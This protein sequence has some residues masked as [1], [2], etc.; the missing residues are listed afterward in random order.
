M[1]GADL[2]LG[3][4]R[5]LYQESVKTTPAPDEFDMYNLTSAPLELDNMAGN[6]RWSSQEAHLRQPLVEQ[7]NRKRLTPQSGVIPGETDQSKR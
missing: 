3:D 1:Q 4:A 6:T 5:R 7:A 2:S